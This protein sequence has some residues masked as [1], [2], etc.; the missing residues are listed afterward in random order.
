MPGADFCSPINIS[1]NAAWPA[2]GTTALSPKSRC[3][4][5]RR[6]LFSMRAFITIGVTADE[7]ISPSLATGD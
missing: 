4:D 5:E 1:A 3:Y 7:T 2:T 6:R